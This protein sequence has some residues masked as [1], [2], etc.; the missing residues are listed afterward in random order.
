[1][2]WTRF[3]S[4]TD[5]WPRSS[6]P[7]FGNLPSPCAPG[8]AAFKHWAGRHACPRRSAP[9][10]KP[11]REGL[12]GFQFTG[13]ER[14][15]RLVPAAPRPQYLPV[16]FVEPYRANRAMAGFDLGS[17]PRLQ[18]TI[19]AARDSGK[20]VMAS[21]IGLLH[22]LPDH[23]AVLV[24]QPVYTEG[25]PIRSV[26]QRQERFRGTVFGIYCIAE[27][28]G[29]ALARLPPESVELRCFDL[30]APKGEPPFCCYPS[31]AARNWP[32]S[33]RRPAASDR[34]GC[35]GRALEIGFRSRARLCRP[36]ANVAAMVHTGHGSSHDRRGERDHFHD[37]RPRNP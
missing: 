25:P 26:G 1:M 23:F 6:A 7:S 21:R 5:R 16:F 24:V 35:G 34:H 29:E 27:L 33:R 14:T 15:G 8:R 4:S 20:P 2:F 9:L 36:A 3:A 31:E 10:G 30:S 37:D 17:N 28:V 11:R 22:E 19:E 18:K 13:R 32:A 12:T